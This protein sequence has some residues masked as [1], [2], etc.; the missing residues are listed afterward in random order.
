M[1]SARVA[2]GLAVMLAAPGILPAAELKPE[3]LRAW[4]AY[5]RTADARMKARL[6]GR[7]PFLWADETPGRSRQLRQGESS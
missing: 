7:R 6:D 5:L 1:K 4:D 2:L 3:T